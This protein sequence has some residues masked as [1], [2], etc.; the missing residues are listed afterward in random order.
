M[1]SNG[2][3]LVP[4]LRQSRLKERTISIEEQRRDIQAWAQ[5]NGVPLAAEVT[6]QR[7][8]GSKPWRERDLGDAVDACE[9]GE[10]SGIIVAWQDRLSR[11]NGRATAE[12]WE[13]LERAG[14][15]FV[16]ANEASTP[17]AAT[18][19]CCSRLKPRSHAT[20]GSFTGR[21]GRPHAGDQ[22][23]RRSRRPQGRRELEIHSGV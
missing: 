2:R 23:V 17:Q 14:A 3:P 21:T 16:A 15:R 4:Y 11:E 19:R 5:A 6:E 22:H 20:S 7:V 13:T 10:A 12:A 1:K 8:S 18:R 9:R